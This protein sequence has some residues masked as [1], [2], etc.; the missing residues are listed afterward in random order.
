MLLT[1][2]EAD[3]FLFRNPFLQGG[4][5]STAPIPPVTES[6]GGWGRLWIEH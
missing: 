6:V 3:G 2:S 5:I 4:A 1:D